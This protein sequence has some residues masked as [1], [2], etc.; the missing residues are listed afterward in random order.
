MLLL[1]AGWAGAA[2]SL[3]PPTL[4]S[5][6]SGPPAVRTAKPQPTGTVLPVPDGGFTV[7]CY[8][9]FALTPVPGGGIASRYCMPVTEFSWEM[10]YL[11]NHGITPISV[12]QLK[13]YWFDGKPLPAKSVLLTFDDGFKSI[14]EIACP[15]VKRYRYPAI[16][17]A[18]TDFIKWQKG[19]LRYDDI[20]TMQKN[21]WSVECHTKSHYNLGLEESKRTPEQFDALLDDELSTSLDFIKDH[22][23]YASGILAYP[24][25]VYDDKVVA[26]AQSMGIS[27]AFGVS[28]GPNDRTVPGMKLHRNLILFPVKHPSFEEIFES[29]VLHLTD[30]YPGDGQ[31]IDD[32]LP[33]LQVKVLDSVVPSTVDLGIDNRPIDYTYD[34]ATRLL[35]HKAGVKIASGGHILTV[36][37]EDAQGKK[38]TYSWYFRIKHYKKK[39][40]AKEETHDVY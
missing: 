32:H 20:Q 27:M 4:T 31:L 3:T 28:P 34:P 21:G 29:K 19:A 40:P 8:H 37:A 1:G 16:L 26:K 22:F 12:E 39:A 13:A 18:Y 33:P 17:F 5:T 6:P 38:Y 11:K 25:G 15:V 10:R 36:K 30:M 35:T 24:Y 14:Y 7:L 2:E 9:R 23:N